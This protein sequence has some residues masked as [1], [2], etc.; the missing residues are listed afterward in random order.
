LPEAQGVSERS[1]G[2]IKQPVVLAD[3][4][5]KGLVRKETC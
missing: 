3:L 1:G 4:Q 5:G 2:K